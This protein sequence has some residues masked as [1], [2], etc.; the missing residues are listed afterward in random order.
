MSSSTR[1]NSRGIIGLTSR[2]RVCCSG[3]STACYRFSIALWR[4]IAGR[5]VAARAIA[6]VNAAVVGLLGAAL[7]DPVWTSAV[8]GPVDIA[9]ALVGF[10][11][12]VAWRASALVL[13]LWCVVTS[14][15]SCNPSIRHLS[16]GISK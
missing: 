3:D 1:N 14:L 7:Y 10:T 2:A 15:A 16:G 5:P 11:L 12:L 8:R 13:V 4:E 6:G 9:I